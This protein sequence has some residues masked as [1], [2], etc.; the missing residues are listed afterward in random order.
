MRQ[1][2]LFV[3]GTLRRGECNHH[4]LAG[5]FDR[6][7]SAQLPGFTRVAPL[8]IARSGGSVVDGE[9]YDLSAENYAM[10][11][12]GC[13]DLEELPVG[14]LVGREYRRVPVRVQ[15]DSS[16]FIAWAYARPDAEPD[17]DLL[18]L[19]AEEWQRLQSAVLIERSDA[20]G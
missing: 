19:V 12:Q 3:F 15:A 4:Y 13:D 11:L 10:T 16:E 5:R 9:L 14:N 6:V 8:M 20:C 7:T 2:P 1:L 17:S 18:P